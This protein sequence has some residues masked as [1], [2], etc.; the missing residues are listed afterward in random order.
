VTVA[1]K[2]MLPALIKRNW[3]GA[4]LMKFQGVQH[5]CVIFNRRQVSLKKR[6]AETTKLEQ[7]MIDSYSLPVDFY[8]N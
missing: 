1:S 7:E 4:N 6:L 8:L 2:N 5:H 3:L